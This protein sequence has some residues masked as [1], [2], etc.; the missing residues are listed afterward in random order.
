MMMHDAVYFLYA[1][2]DVTLQNIISHLVCYSIETYG[3]MHEWNGFKMFNQVA[4]VQEIYKETRIT[5]LV[6]VIQMGDKQLGVQED[7]KVTNTQVKGIY[8]E[9][10]NTVAL[11]LVVGSDTNTH[12]IDMDQLM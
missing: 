1:M 5:Q 9:T 7:F 8:Q 10:R 11:I 3:N 12:S 2:I 6:A 4:S